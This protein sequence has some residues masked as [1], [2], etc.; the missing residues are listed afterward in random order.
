M[1]VGYKVRVAFP[2]QQ[3]I[4][5][6][7]P[8]GLIYINANRNVVAILDFYD[9]ADPATVIHTYWTAASDLS[10]AAIDAQARAIAATLVSQAASVKAITTDTF[11]IP[12]PVDP[13][14]QAVQDA[15]FALRQVVGKAQFDG[16]VT[17]LAATNQE[18][19]DAKTAVDA[20]QAILAG[21][22]PADKG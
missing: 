4:G 13:N 1:T 7:S 8:S 11:K 15:Q 19:A 10:D 6:Q 22:M 12:D 21:A 2:D 16:L 18:V 17:S 20:A 3:Q 9:D 14:V 5:I